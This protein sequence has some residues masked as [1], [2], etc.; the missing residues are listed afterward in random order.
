MRPIHQ[1]DPKEHLFRDPLCVYYEAITARAPDA[2]HNVKRLHS[3]RQ[4]KY[5]PPDDAVTGEAVLTPAIL[6]KK[7]FRPT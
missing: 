6:S 2:P 1:S 7:Q 5:V 3:P 4:G